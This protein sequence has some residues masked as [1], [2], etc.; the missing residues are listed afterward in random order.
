MLASKKFGGITARK[1]LV[2]LVLFLLVSQDTALLSNSYAEHNVLEEVYL[3]PRPISFLNGISYVDHDMLSLALGGEAYM[4]FENFTSLIEAY[5]IPANVRVIGLSVGWEEHA[6]TSSS[7]IPFYKWVDDFLEAT[8]RYDIDVFI[9]FDPLKSLDSENSWWYDV[10]RDKP[11]FQPLFR[12]RVPNATNEPAL[13]FADSPLVLEQLEEDLKQLYAYYGKHT[14]WKGISLGRSGR[15]NSSFPVDD[16]SNKIVCNNLTLNNFLDSFFF[17]RDVNANGVH[18]NGTSCKLWQQFRGNEPLLVFSSGYVQRSYPQDLVG[19]GGI[20][21]IV[22]VF[23]VNS[24]TSGFK[25]SW[26][27]RRVGS[28]GELR[29]DLYNVDVTHTD[30]NTSSLETVSIPPELIGSQIGWQPFVEFHSKLE[31]GVTYSIVFRCENGEEPGKYEVYYRNWRV[32]ESMLLVSSDS[33]Q[34]LRWQFKGS[35]IMWIKDLQGED[36][37]IYPYQDRGIIRNDKSNVIQVF[38]SPGDLKF[39]IIF[40]SVSDRPYDESIATLKI[41]R[42][43]DGKVIARGNI[44]P[45]YT[46]GMYWWLPVPLESEA[47]LEAGEEYTLVVERM[48]TG[49]GWQIHYLITDPAIA[50]PQGNNKMLLFRLAYID[51]IFINFMKIGPPGRAGPE[52]GWP[53]VE[54]RT[55]WAQRYIVSRTARLLNVE[56]NIEKYGNPGDLIVRLREDNGTGLAP[57]DDDIEAMRIPADDI[58]AGRVWLNITGWNTTLTSGKMYWVVLSTDEAP[59]GNGYWPWKIEYAYQFLIKRSDDAGISWVR[60][61]EPAELYVNLFTTEEAFINEPEDIIGQTF[62]KDKKQVAQSFMLEDDTYVQGLLVF[63]SRSPSDRDGLLTVEIRSDNGFD[64]PSTTILTSGVVRMVEDK[65][66]F[67]GMQIV[68]FKYPYFLKAGVKYWVVIR[69]DSSSEVEP[70]VFKF[71]YPELSY[72]GTQLKVKITN[73]GGQTWNLPNGEEADLLFGLVKSPYNPYRFTAQELAKDLEVYHIHSVREEPLRGLNIYLGFQVSDLRKKLVQWFETYTGRNWFSLGFDHPRLLEEAGEYPGSFCVINIGNISEVDKIFTG[74][75]I[76]TIVPE[77]NLTRRALPL[78]K[79]YYDEAMPSYPK[80]LTLLN[81]EDIRSLG[82]AVGSNVSNFWNISRLMMYAGENYGRSR[83]AVRAL[84]IGDDDSSILA[85]HLLSTVNVTLATIKEDKN[86]SRFDDFSSFDVIVLALGKSSMN[87]ITQDARQRIKEFV[88]GGGGLVVMFSWSEWVDEIVGFRFTSDE[89]SRGSLHEVDYRHPVLA[90]F[91][92][93]GWYVS[94]WSNN[95]IYQISQNVSFIIKD[96]NN[97]PWVSANT[98]GLGRGVLC[99][100]PFKDESKIRCDYLVMLTNAIFY[101]AKIENALPILWYGG[102]TGKSTLGELR[103]SITGKSGGPILLWLSGYNK[104]RFEVHLNASFFNIDPKG[105]IVLDA[106]SW[107][108]VVRGNGSEISIQFDTHFGAWS[109]LYVLNDTKDALAL[110]SNAWVVSQKIYPN[111]ALYSLHALPQQDVL[112]IVKSA[113]A[114]Y[115]VTLDGSPINRTEELPLVI[116]NFN[117]SVYFYDL[118][119]RMFYMKAKVQGRDLIVRI[120]FDVPRPSF[121]SSVVEYGQFI[122][123]IMLIV[124]F[125]I[126]ELYVIRRIRLRIGSNV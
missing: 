105:W 71:H 69:G 19:T 115:K 8:D 2:F 97:Q 118:N 24:S 122:C 28:P 101:A 114:P 55:W 4:N 48:S 14:S 50:G 44:K 102:L 106:I 121:L 1:V 26:Y 34:R 96:T 93:V 88:K 37:L 21:A 40:L 12:N 56:I 120:I 6:N 82:S 108:P 33:G 75:P 54:Y 57:G 15:F 116:H 35:T 91:T 125:T 53:G 74:F 107:L 73:D 78:T 17:L 95:K 111:Q 63:L 58:P 72:G 60:P 18:A 30:L 90:S 119:N 123:A 99:G 80:P 103:Y 67:K 47:I 117:E 36:L 110:Y 126:V 5:F 45:S 62:T 64:S 68:T 3:S 113:T 20:R 77:I 87:L 61:R 10:L 65:I 9:V 79:A 29:L 83:A 13:L 52:A 81:L 31:G 59:E 66:T 41:T 104:T 112:L 100:S 51:P 32:D 109:P 7:D 23:N 89:I 25:V 27:G 43:S 84:L 76:A 38:R 22:M 46:K 86:F 16:L 49:E 98:Y 92:D 124:S 94:N 85:R 39:N 11:E 42:N 70:L